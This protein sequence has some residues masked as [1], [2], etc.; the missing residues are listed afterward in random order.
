MI[1]RHCPIM[2]NNLYYFFILPNIFR[3]GFYLLNN[4]DWWA[5]PLDVQSKVILH[6]LSYFYCLLEEPHLTLFCYQHQSHSHDQ[7][8]DQVS[9][10][11]QSRFVL[12]I[13]QIFLAEKNRYLYH[14]F[15]ISY[16]Y[17]L[18][19]KE[20]TLTFNRC[21]DLLVFIWMFWNNMSNKVFP[22]FVSLITMFTL[23]L[24]IRISCSLIICFRFFW[25]RGT[26]R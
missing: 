16:V 8:Q 3:H 26:F 14:L 18:K 21:F 22:N 13:K 7:N 25:I 24:V 12:V 11:I 9:C 4:H 17:L 1:F 23:A 20:N 15:F 5:A 6:H 2:P 19:L 10:L